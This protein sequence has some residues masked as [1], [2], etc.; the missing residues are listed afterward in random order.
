MYKCWRYWYC[1]ICAWLI[2]IQEV[3]ESFQQSIHSTVC[4]DVVNFHVSEL[5]TSIMSGV[6]TVHTED[7][8][9][10]SQLVNKMG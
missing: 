1:V 10:Q 8:H 3:P 6:G 5:E 7:E 4:A 9:E 2:K